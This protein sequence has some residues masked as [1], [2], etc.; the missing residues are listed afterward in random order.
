LKPNLFDEIKSL[1]IEIEEYSEK[2]IIYDKFNPKIEDILKA[3]DFPKA[4][5]TKAN[6]FEKSDAI[7]KDLSSYR[8]FFKELAASLK[9]NP[10]SKK[11]PTDLVVEKLIYLL[12]EYSLSIKPKVLLFKA[13]AY[14]VE[15]GIICGSNGIKFA[16]RKLTK[17]FILSEENNSTDIFIYVATIG[18]KIDDEIKKLADSG[19]IFES[20]MLNGIGGA[21][22]E[23]AA[24]DLNIYFNE[25]LNKGS[26]DFAF[27]RYSPG[28]GDW[29]VADQKKIFSL[30]NP[31][32]HIG[33]NLSDSF[34]MYPE[35]STSGVIGLV[36]KPADYST[37]HSGKT[38]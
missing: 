6:F 38:N 26:V 22:A 8:Y 9:F 15:D 28:Y 37:T 19:D 31:Q 27:N 29:D 17:N 7:L 12:K 35:K 18:G 5:L 34:L 32:K 10:L 3:L 13:A 16:S 11:H 23:M 2:K 14:F 30:L 36:D 4:D 24:H 33:V 1:R 20:Y 25:A 21:A